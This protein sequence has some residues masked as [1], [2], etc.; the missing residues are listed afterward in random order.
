MLHTELSDIFI[1]FRIAKNCD[2][3]QIWNMLHSDTHVYNRMW[4]EEMIRIHIHEF[5]VLEYGGKLAG[6]LHGNFLIPKPI[7]YSTLVHPKYPDE[8]VRLV[9][10]FL[11]NG[12]IMR[13]P[14]FYSKWK[15]YEKLC[16]TNRIESNIFK[17]VF[18]NFGKRCK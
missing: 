16:T 17:K 12:I 4:N 11:V 9:M 3:K 2:I 10:A 6:L 5:L 8:I 15:Y 1:T 18:G 13:Q 7:I 14:V